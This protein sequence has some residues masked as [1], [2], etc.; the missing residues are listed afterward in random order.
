MRDFQKKKPPNFALY[1]IQKKIKNAAQI[2]KEK[3]T[4]TSSAL[5][6]REQPQAAWT[7]APVISIQ[8]ILS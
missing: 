8:F 7:C 2:H 5:K 6:E 4:N 3:H 1:Y